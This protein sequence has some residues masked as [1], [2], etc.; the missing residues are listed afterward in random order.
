MMY[1]L[2]DKKLCAVAV[3]EVSYAILENA[4][5]LFLQIL[6]LDDPQ[7]TNFQLSLKG[8]MQFTYNLVCFANFFK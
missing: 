8:E 4:S 2:L 5:V 6:G 7:L 1:E 3:Y